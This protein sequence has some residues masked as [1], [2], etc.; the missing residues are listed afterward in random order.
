[1][2]RFAGL[3]W[4]HCRPSAGTLNSTSGRTL[5]KASEG[6]RTLDIQLGKPP[7][8]QQTLCDPP[9]T[10]CKF[11]RFWG[12]NQGV[13]CQFPATKLTS[14]LLEVALGQLTPRA[15]ESNTNFVRAKCRRTVDVRSRRASNRGGT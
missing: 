4:P 15:A 9:L 3:T 5:K 8:N 13:T 12:A 7:T 6:I 10:I 1:M 11:G 14:S 2:Y